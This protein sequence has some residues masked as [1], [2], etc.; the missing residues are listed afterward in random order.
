MYIKG[1]PYLNVLNIMVSGMHDASFE[2]KCTFNHLSHR[3]YTQNK[4][5]HHI[6]DTMLQREISLDFST[7]VLYFKFHFMFKAHIVKD[8]TCSEL[9]HFIKQISMYERYIYGE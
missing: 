8:A 5:Y 2:N 6:N 9:S 3:N 7:Q 1:K 4:K